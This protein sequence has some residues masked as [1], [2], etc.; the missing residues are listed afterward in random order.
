MAFRLS[1][2]FRFEAAH[3]LALNYCGKCANIHGHSWNGLLQVSGPE[4][5]EFSFLIDFADIKVFTK[6]Q[7]DKYDHK[8]LVQEKDSDLIAL[9]EKQHWAIEI[10][11]DN[12]TSETLAKTI[13]DEAV[14]YFAKWPELSVDFV[15]I[16]ETCT[17]ECIYD[18]K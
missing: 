9:C 12:P 11:A 4:L 16:E 13:Y 18:G 6:A 15:K 2:K 8:L 17:S 5:D 7:E 14:A 3:R 1:K 10:F